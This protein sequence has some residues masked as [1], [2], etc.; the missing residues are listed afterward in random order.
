[1]NLQTLNLK[2]LNGAPASAVVL[3]VTENS[4][5]STTVK[6]L[7]SLPK[8]FFI[9]PSIQKENGIE[10]LQ[11]DLEQKRFTIESLRK[12]I[13]EK[14]GLSVKI[15][16]DR[17]GIIAGG[18]VKFVVGSGTE[19]NIST[20]PVER[21]LDGNFFTDYFVWE[22]TIEG[23][24]MISPRAGRGRADLEKCVRFIRC[25]INGY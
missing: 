12:Q 7:G 10:R 9:T 2:N 4:S 19:I 15:A 16:S 3:G 11:S 21:E 18:F 22:I 6:K 14:L 20:L 23:S 17:R 1:M 24:A 13:T 5:K 25:E 8:G